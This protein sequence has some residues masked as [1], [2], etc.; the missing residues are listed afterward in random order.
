[1]DYD[2]FSNIGREEHMATL[3]QDGKVLVAGGDADTIGT[4]ASAETY[5]PLTGTV[6]NHRQHE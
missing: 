6:D 1:M 3:L 2:G 5:H 4:L